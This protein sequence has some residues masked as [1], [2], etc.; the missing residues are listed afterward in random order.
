MFRAL[1]PGTSI[2]E[3]SLTQNIYEL[4]KALGDAGPGQAYIQTVPR[5]GYRFVAPVSGSATNAITLAVRPLRALHGDISTHHLGL[6]I[7]DALPR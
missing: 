5:R 4:R 1:W 3:S 6:G 7:S 2:E